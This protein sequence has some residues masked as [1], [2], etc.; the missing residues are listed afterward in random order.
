MFL[1]IGAFA[2]MRLRPDVSATVE[3]HVRVHEKNLGSTLAQAANEASFEA[4][5][6]VS[7]L[8]VP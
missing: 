8:R 7:F 2:G 4:Q 5:K 3:F 1:W 6:S